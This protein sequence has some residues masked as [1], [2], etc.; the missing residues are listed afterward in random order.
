MA[1]SRRRGFAPAIESDAQLATHHSRSALSIGG[2]LRFVTC[3]FSVRHLGTARVAPGRTRD[4]TVHVAVAD[5][6]HEGVVDCP[7]ESAVWHR[8][9]DLVRGQ[10]R[11][12]EADVLDLF[13]RMSL[14]EDVALEIV[15]DEDEVGQA[16]GGPVHSEHVVVEGEVAVR[17]E[18]E[19]GLVGEVRAAHGVVLN[20]LEAEELH[21]RPVACVECRIKR[22]DDGVSRDE[23]AVGEHG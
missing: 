20:E 5:V 17:H 22:L 1:Q 7:L 8:A 9:G 3:R 12:R 21:G 18:Q 10:V 4:R 23:L 2:L 16:G 13:W 15:A 14:V 6:L 11:Q 19:R